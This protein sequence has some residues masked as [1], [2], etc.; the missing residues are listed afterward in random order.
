MEH[1]L[2]AKAIGWYQSRPLAYLDI[3]GA[4]KDNGSRDTIF[5]HSN[6]LL[7]NSLVMPESSL[8]PWDENYE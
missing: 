7:D 6:L 8:M 5:L 4:H 2:E 3:F 1:I